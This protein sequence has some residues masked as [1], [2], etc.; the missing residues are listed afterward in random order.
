MPL[1]ILKEFLQWAF[2]ISH[3]TD[4]ETEAQRVNYRG[5]SAAYTLTV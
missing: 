1:D 4:R 2:L 5:T 3:F